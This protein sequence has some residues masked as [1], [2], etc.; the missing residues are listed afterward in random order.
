MMISGWGLVLRPLG[1]VNAA[2]MAQSVLVKLGGKFACAVGRIP[3][4]EGAEAGQCNLQ[5]QS[6]CREHLTE[7]V[8]HPA[9]A[10]RGP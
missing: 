3:Q 8:V 2:R 10:H 1:V 5:Q 4:F 7:T 6:E 9:A